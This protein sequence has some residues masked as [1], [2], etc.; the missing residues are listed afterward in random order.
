MGQQPGYS[1][2]RPGMEF[3]IKQQGETRWYP[4]SVRLFDDV[5]AATIYSY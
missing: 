1:E 2:P 5:K 3:R 4:L